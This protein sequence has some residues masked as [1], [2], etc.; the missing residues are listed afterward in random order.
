MTTL[1]M[2]DARH[3]FTEIANKVMVTGE[4]IYISKNNKPAFAVVPITDVQLLQA[5]EDKIDLEEAL[6][7]LQESDSISLEELEKQAGI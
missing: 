2:T 3:T 6:A 4:R 7:S 1:S 5:L